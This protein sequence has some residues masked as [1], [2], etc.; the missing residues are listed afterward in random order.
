MVHGAEGWDEPTPM[1]R[2]RCSMC[3]AAHVAV[4]IAR[5]RTMGWRAVRQ[6]RS[7]AATPPTMRAR[8]APCCTAR[9]ADAHRD[10]LLLG[11]AL[12]LEVAGEERSRRA[13]G[14][15]RGAAIDGGAARR[16]LDV[17]VAASRRVPHER[18]FSHA[19]G[20]S[21]RAARRGRQRLCP[22][23]RMLANRRSDAAAPHT[24]GAERRGLRH[25]RGT[26]A[27]LAR[28]RSAARSG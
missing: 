21:S 4:A 23:A 22:A 8:C 25:D 13:G 24:A 3:I 17:G 1:G 7:P 10:C 5:P 9:I 6:H 14:G 26:E 15:A 11:A 28:G 16:V 19:D 20:A 18:R 2:S 27:A 12:A